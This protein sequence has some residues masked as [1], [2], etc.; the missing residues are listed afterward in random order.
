VEEKAAGI[1]NLPVT[2][3][4][5]RTDNTGSPIT[6][7]QV[8]QTPDHQPNL[9]FQVIG[10]LTAILVRTLNAFVTTYIGIAT[11]AGLG[12]ASLV[13]YTNLKDLLIKSAVLSLS[14]AVL[15]FLKSVATI[16]G[17]LE[18]NHPLLTGSV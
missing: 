11:A 4:G 13:P 8:I 2:V 18:K 10:P 15:V 9:V 6:N 14:G 1:E 3:I 5:V 12:G 16:L 17:D 7:G